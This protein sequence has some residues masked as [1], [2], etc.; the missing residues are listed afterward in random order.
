MKK[1]AITIKIKEVQRTDTCW[2]LK[3]HTY[4]TGEFMYP[5]GEFIIVTKFGGHVLRHLGSGLANV[6]R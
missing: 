6:I 3:R 2:N 4:P 1:T 5:T